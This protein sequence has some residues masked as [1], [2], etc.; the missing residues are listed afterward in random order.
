MP[1]RL[2]RWW[3]DAPLRVKGIV[4]IGI[5]LM[6]L[7]VMA[8]LFLLGARNAGTSADW[9]GRA[10]R[11]QTQLATVLRLVVDADAAIAEFSA[12]HRPDA[13]GPAEAADGALP[14]AVDRLGALVWDNPDQVRHV[15]AVAAMVT[16]RPFAA[17][18]DAAH[19]RRDLPASDPLVAD[20]RASAAALRREL[21][22]MQELQDRLLAARADFVRRLLVWLAV[23]GAVFGA[24]FGMLG[25]TAFVSGVVSRIDRLRA[26]AGH[27]AHGEALGPPHEAS[28]ELGE[29]TRSIH[30]AAATLRVRDVEVRA[31]VRELATVNRDLDLAR[32]ELDQFFSLSLD[33]LGI[34]APDGCF[35]RVN[36]AWEQALGWTPEE[37]TGMPYVDFVHRDDRAATIAEAERMTGGD[38]TSGFENR[39]PAKGR[40]CT[41]G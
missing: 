34:A 15:R 41:D 33:L 2:I 31:H 26:D 5:P 29:L 7:V 22:A 30:E 16:P 14:A 9:M 3:D 4:V 28:D 36:P 39:Y 35:K 20:S 23:V 6:P 1:A 8:A 24:I 18:V 10:Y 11:T 38:A 32:E 17:V 25:M 21:A 19:Q 27:L 40:F 37:L 13:L 12:T